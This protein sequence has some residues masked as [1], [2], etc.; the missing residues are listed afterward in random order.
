MSSTENPDSVAA[1]QE[2]EA[3]RAEATALRR[4]LV[5]PSEQVRDL[6]AR[7]DSLTVRNGKLMDTSK[8]PASS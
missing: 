6:E 4:R 2:L 5:E 7:I 1:A 8:R 3:L